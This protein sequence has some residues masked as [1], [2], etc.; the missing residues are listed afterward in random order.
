MK[1]PARQAQPGPALDE[2][3][4][5]AMG[6]TTFDPN[7]DTDELPLL[8]IGSGTLTGWALGEYPVGERWGSAPGLFAPRGIF[9]PSQDWAA[10]G[11]VQ[12]A[13]TGWLYQKRTEY[14][15]RLGE[16]LTGNGKVLVWPDALMNFTPANVCRAFLLANGVEEIESK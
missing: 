1:T 15:N 13:A 6:W 3:V 10:A 7:E 2:A 14:T 5:R 12:Q 16:L 8:W 11:L 4:A 9:R